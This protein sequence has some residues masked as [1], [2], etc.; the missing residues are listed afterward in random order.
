MAFQEGKCPKCGAGLDYGSGDT[1]YDNGLTY[2][3]SC[4]A[5]G[6]RGAEFHLGS[7]FAG[8]DDA[9]GNALEPPPPET[10]DHEHDA[11]REYGVEDDD[12]YSRLDPERRPGE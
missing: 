3:C 12:D 5:C 8:F 6:F 11:A 1:D 2:A 10:S 9:D 7:G 4:S